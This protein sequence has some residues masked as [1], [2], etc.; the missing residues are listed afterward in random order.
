MS[1][2]NDK[3]I[4]KC[5]RKN[6]FFAWYK[7]SCVFD[8][9]FKRSS[10]TTI[11][12]ILSL[13]EF[14]KKRPPRRRKKSDPRVISARFE[15]RKVFELFERVV[16]RFLKKMR[17]KKISPWESRVSTTYHDFQ[18][19]EVRKYLIHSVEWKRNKIYNSYQCLRNNP[20][21]TIESDRLLN[22]RTA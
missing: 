16:I 3:N 12:V 10:E 1:D 2:K 7:V 22:H 13:R 14:L 8:R 19:G 9:F 20:H 6:H 18:S 5:W 17:E 21:K 4:P 11:P 15:M